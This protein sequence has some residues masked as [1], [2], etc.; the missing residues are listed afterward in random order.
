MKNN[1]YTIILISILG[2]ACGESLDG[3]GTINVYEFVDYGGSDGGSDDVIPVPE[4][5]PY[6][7]PDPYVEPKPYVDPEPYVD[8]GAGVYFPGDHNMVFVDY[9]VAVGWLDVLDCRARHDYP[10]CDVY[11]YP[12]DEGY[13]TTISLK[14][15]GL[16]NPN[17]TN[18]V[19]Q[20]S[21]FDHQGGL[22]GESDYSDRF[23]MPRADRVEAVW[24]NFA[25]PIR[26]NETAIMRQVYR[27]PTQIIASIISNVDGAPVAYFEGTVRFRTC[28]QCL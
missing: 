1:L 16:L 6:V 9:D 26:L 25:S 22:I 3:S 19:V 20:L 5:E 4:L 21:L 24:V 15:W 17:T 18:F 28:E 8:P 27:Y 2:T 10:G 13:E 11:L 14:I 23:Q 7:D 12:V